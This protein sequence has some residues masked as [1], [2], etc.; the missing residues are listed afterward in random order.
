MKAI[1]T[2][3]DDY[4]WV[5]ADGNIQSAE[6]GSTI[7]VD[8]K[9]FAR[10]EGALSK[11]ADAKAGFPKSHDEL[12]ALAAENDVTWPEGTKTTAA[13]VEALVAAGV[14]PPADDE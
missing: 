1:V 14:E 6:R 13:K 11:P 4:R 3:V 10:I 12:D 9:E 8:E 7:D 5:D 2:G